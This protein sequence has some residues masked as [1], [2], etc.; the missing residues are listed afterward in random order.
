MKAVFVCVLALAALLVSAQVVDLTPENFDSVVD[1]SKNVFV[2]FFAPWCGHCKNL[3]PSWELLGGAFAGQDDVVIAKVDADSHRELGTRFGVS[4]F[5]TLK[6]F[7]KGDAAKPKDYSGGREFDDLVKYVA[8]ETGARAKVA[9]KPVSKVT[10]LDPVN[11][12]QVIQDK[13]KH[14]FVEFYAPWC[15]HCKHLAPDWEKLGL[16]FQNEHDVVIAKVDADKHKPLGE[17][18][19]VSGFPTLKFFPKDNKAGE[20]YEAGRDLE[21]LVA[22]VNKRAGLKRTSKGL[23]ESTVGRTAELDQLASTYLRDV[24]TREATLKAAEAAVKKAHDPNL[25]WYVKFMRAIEKKGVAFVE[26]EKTRLEGYLGDNKVEAKKAD[27]FSIRLNVLEA[28][29]A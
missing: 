4:G 29:K 26:A 5:P 9:P 19:G 2:E 25:E 12:E 28:F 1:G 14:V 24:K 6:L 27:E 21:S 23:F 22:E 3:A 7:S 16:A 10:V 8:E 18:F 20:S 11:F 13:S 15:G 17:K